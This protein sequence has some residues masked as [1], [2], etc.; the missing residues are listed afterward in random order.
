VTFTV[1]GTTGDGKPYSIQVREDRLP[2]DGTRNVVELLVRREGD[3]YAVT[4][5]GPFGRLDLKKPSTVLGA[6]H[7]WTRVAQVTG[8]A[9][10][11]VPP[12]ESGVVYLSASACYDPV[13]EGDRLFY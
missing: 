3:E 6:L 7:A 1:E 2:V 13:R 9:P 10:E 5:T 4:P 8:V 12:V 11:I